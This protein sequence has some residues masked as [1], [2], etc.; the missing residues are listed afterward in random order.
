MDSVEVTCDLCHGNSYKPEVLSY[1]LKDKTIVDILSMPVE[2][3]IGFFDGTDIQPAL[4][5]LSDVGLEYLTIGQTLNTLS[6]GERQ[7]L[8][9]AN[10]L[11]NKGNIY[12]FDEPTTG[13]HGSDTYKLMKLFDNL[14][15]EGNTV[16]II[17][18][19]LDIISKSDWIIDLGPGAGRNGGTIIFE[20][21]PEDI[22]KNKQ[23]V[24]GK[25]LRKYLSK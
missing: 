14:T 15:D 7:R 13:L 22:I 3:A 18:H 9:L 2:E 17:E 8:K 24:T 20:G 19:N 1:K 4:K 23:S 5:R 10:E 25:Y 6:G 16:I 12:V 21:Y 11:G